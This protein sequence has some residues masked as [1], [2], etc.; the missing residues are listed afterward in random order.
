MKVNKKTG[1]IKLEDGEKR[2]G[3]FVVKKEKLHMKI[4][5]ISE[6]FSYRVATHIPIGRFLEASYE[7]MAQEDTHKGI[8]N[9]I[10]VMWTVLA[11]VPDVQFLTEIYEAAVACMKR[12]PGCYGLPDHEL[13]QEEHDAILESEKGLHEAVQELNGLKEKDEENED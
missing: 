3:N 5:D 2:N 10:G 9:Y 12:N 7:D 13:T 1:K 4:F 8:G 11:T 6:L